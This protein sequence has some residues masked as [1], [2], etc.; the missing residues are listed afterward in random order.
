MEDT[1]KTEMGPGSIVRLKSGGPKMKVVGAHSRGWLCTWE[2]GADGTPT[3]FAFPEPCI[4][5]VTDDGM[6]ND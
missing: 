6:V 5:L 3:F 1:K 2:E 4:E